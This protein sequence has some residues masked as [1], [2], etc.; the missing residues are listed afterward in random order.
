MS[1]RVHITTTTTVVTVSPIARVLRTII[2]TVIAF[3]AAEP[4][5]IG[6]LGLTG[7]QASKVAAI[8]AGFVLTVTSAQNLLEHFG[9]LP[10][11]G[12]KV[13]VAKS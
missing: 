7:T 3:G 13:P 12:G 4:T 2:Q 6:G 8:V 10:V 9:V 1:Q 5:L 11:A